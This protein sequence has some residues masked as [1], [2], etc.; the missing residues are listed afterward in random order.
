MPLKINAV[1]QHE[2]DISVFINDWYVRF[3]GSAI[4]L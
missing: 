2:D 1:Q 4:N 3:R